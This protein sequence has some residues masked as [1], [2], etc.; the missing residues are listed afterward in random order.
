MCVLNVGTGA[1]LRARPVTSGDSGIR[2]QLPGQRVQR[3]SGG[4][5]L[6]C[7]MCLLYAGCCVGCYCIPVITLSPLHRRL[8]AARGFSVVVLFD[9]LRAIQTLTLTLTPTLTPTLTKTLTLLMQ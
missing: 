5:V 9:V 4:V 6:F 3:V 1:G 2:V 8:Y 7:M